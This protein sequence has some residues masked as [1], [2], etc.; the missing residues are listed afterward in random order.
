[1][2][3]VG[4]ML[5]ADGIGPVDAALWGLQEVLRNSEGKAHT[6]AQVEGYFS[7]AGFGDIQ[8]RDFVPGVLR[9]VSGVKGPRTTGQ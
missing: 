4:E 7:A 3:L 1:M 6:A 9:R 2:H 5:N 8:T